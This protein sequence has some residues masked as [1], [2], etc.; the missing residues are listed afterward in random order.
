MHDQTP[1]AATSHA[2]DADGAR[3][4]RAGWMLTAAALV[5]ALV[6][7][8]GGTAASGHHVPVDRHTEVPP[9]SLLDPRS[10]ASAELGR[11]ARHQLQTQKQRRAAQ[12]TPGARADRRRTRLRHSG[13][14]RADAAAVYR[15]RFGRSAAAPPVRLTEDA[16]VVDFLNPFTV[17]VRDGADG[18][19]RGRVLV[20][21]TPVAAPGEDGDLHAIDLAL[22][23]RGDAFAPRR[24]VTPLRIAARL[25]DGIDV[26]GGVVLRPEAADADA[27]GVAVGGSVLYANA[28]RDA[29]VAVRPLPNGVELYDVVRSDQAPERFALTV[30][31]T[32][33]ELRATNG[34]DVFE[35][36]S[37]GT[38]AGRFTAASALDAAGRPVATKTRADGNRLIV[39]VAHRGA[40]VAYPI[41]VDPP[42]VYDTFDWGAGTTD[43]GQWSAA[44]P[45]GWA[46]EAPAPTSRYGLYWGGGYL[47]TGYWVAHDAPG[48]WFNANEE[49]YWRY[50][51]PG[52]AQ[53][54]QATIGKQSIDAPYGT[55]ACM[56]SGI[57]SGWVDGNR[58]YWEAHRS[59]C[60]DA[61]YE[62]C[63]G[64]NWIDEWQTHNAGG[65]FENSALMGV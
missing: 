22:A 18:P 60:G 13:L 56:F 55:G 5:T 58:P 46:P 16:E 39:E 36:R 17:R 24:A 50:F 6:V 62:V 15:A 26:G 21:T 33:T 64:E 51:P 42:Y 25:G 10:P 29:D 9:T 54:T 32:G 28:G 41:L 30:L 23:R 27:E 1:R 3:S 48:T 63:C 31:G 61:P 7:A 53:V 43:Q 44:S 45:A 19:R 47:G 20:S 59:W 40:D 12:D 49:A 35:V 8:L 34:G 4:A 38:V 11:E 57:I 52:A 65:T 37:G 2:H 14:G